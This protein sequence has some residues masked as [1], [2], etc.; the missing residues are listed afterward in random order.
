MITVFTTLNSLYIKG[1]TQSD[2]IIANRQHPTRLHRNKS[3][4]NSEILGHKKKAN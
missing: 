3:R 2:E 1:L 4:E